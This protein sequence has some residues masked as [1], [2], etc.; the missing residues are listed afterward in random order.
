MIGLTLARV[1]DPVRLHKIGYRL[2]V[3]GVTVAPSDLREPEWES[4]YWCGRDGPR[5]VVVCYVPELVEHWW[6]RVRDDGTDRP[7]I[8][9]GQTLPEAVSRAMRSQ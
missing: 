9:S 8:G 4:F 7:D 6:V 1:D 3:A 5:L 2:L